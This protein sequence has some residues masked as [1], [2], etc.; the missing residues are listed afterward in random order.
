MIVILDNPISQD[1]GSELFGEA[2]E[3]TKGNSLS[4]LLESLEKALTTTG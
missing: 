4:P 1:E 3:E 2:G